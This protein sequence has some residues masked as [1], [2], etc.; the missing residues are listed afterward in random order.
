M[1]PRISKFLKEI[2]EIVRDPKQLLRDRVTARRVRD[3][4]RWGRVR[5]LYHYS[6]EPDAVGPGD[7]TFEWREIDTEAALMEGTERYIP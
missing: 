7:E 4:I 1:K 6:D 5:V 3:L 2:W